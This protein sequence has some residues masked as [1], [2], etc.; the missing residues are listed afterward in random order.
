M[1]SM[2]L[3]TDMFDENNEKESTVDR[4][5]LRSPTRNRDCCK[6]YSI[7]GHDERFFVSESVD[8]SDFSPKGVKN[9]RALVSI[10]DDRFFLAALHRKPIDQVGSVKESLNILEV[11]DSLPAGRCA[12]HEP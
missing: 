6:W 1:S 2:F 4:D 3:C 9:F 11:P 8:E 12:F 5:A 7:P 10:L